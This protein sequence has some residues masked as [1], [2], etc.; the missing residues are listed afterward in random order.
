MAILRICFVGDSITQGTADKDYL[1]WPGRVCAAERAR[2]H[3][4]TCYNL[5]V[6]ADTSA[7][8][9]RRWR[10]ECEA[11]LPAHVTG[12]LVFAFGVNDSAI[13]NDSAHPR[14]PLPDAL[15]TARAVL[16]AAKVWKRTLWVG[17][18]PVEESRQPLR[19]APTIAYDFRNRRIADYNRAFA[20]L[21]AELGLAYLDLFTPL[22]ADARWARAAGGGDGVHP[23]A[24]GYA[25]IAE[26]VAAWP[27]WRSWLDS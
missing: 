11:R 25:L 1:G 14:V 24:E 18:A 26:R 9:A 17:P 22:G 13:E 5:G 3:D 16:G 8:I 19:P 15:A 21:A 6:R 10:A 12:A 20:A 4:L 7:D 23:P 2:G 27:A